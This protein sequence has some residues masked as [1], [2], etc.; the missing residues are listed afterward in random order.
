[1]NETANVHE[2]AGGGGSLLNHLPTIFWQRR[3]LVIIPFV[4]L[5]AAGIAAAYMLPAVYRSSATLLVESQDLPSS[6]VQLPEESYINQRIAKIRA[7]ALSRGNLIELIQQNNLY[8]AQRQSKPLSTVIETMRENTAIEA[9]AA[10]IGGDSNNTIAFSMSFQYHEAQPAQLVV[11]ELVRRFL[12]LDSSQTSEQAESTV[13]FLDTQANELQRQIVGIEQQI[14]AFKR[15]NGAL[16]TGGGFPVMVS[17]GSYDTQISALRRD[18]ALLARQ[19]SPSTR[20]PA[21]AAAEAQLETARTLYSDNH[22]DVKMLERRLEV[23]RRTAG[24]AATSSGPDPMIASQI[25]ANIAQIAALERARDTDVA[26]AA[27]ARGAQAQGP[28]MLERIAQLESRADTLRT[29][30]RTVAQNLMTART[31]ARMK[32][33]Q[34]GERLALIEAPV[35][36]DRPIWPNRPLIMLGGIAGGLLAG[37]VLALAVELVLRPIRGPGEIERLTGAAPLGVIPMFQ[38]QK[39]RRRGRRLSWR[40]VTPWRRAA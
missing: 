25:E 6:V 37:L 26:Q 11:Q 31:A 39:S 23:V 28:V 17:T 21:L 34:R 40:G 29:Q 15:Q 30:H 19:S 5:S 3:W 18:N 38:D 22:P 12:D 20:D 33:E 9:V 13:E 14:T 35:V 27:A 8:A 36:A 10:N 2:E 16:L 32:E 1:M 4:L 24:S 7:Q